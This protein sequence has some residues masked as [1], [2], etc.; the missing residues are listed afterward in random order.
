MADD[1][2]KRERPRTGRAANLPERVL[3]IAKALYE[4]YGADRVILFGSVA[5]GETR[6]W[7]DIDLLVIKDGEREPACRR[8]GRA[9]RAMGDAARGVSMDVLVNTEAEIEAEIARGNYFYQDMMEEGI[10]I[11]R[12]LA[13][14]R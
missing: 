1:D 14:L 2:R 3:R 10:V 12:E 11:D 7:S 6:E 9:R 4:N 8:S 13:L 5:R